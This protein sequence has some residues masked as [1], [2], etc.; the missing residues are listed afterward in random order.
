[1]GTMSNLLTFQGRLPG[2]VCEAALPPS[3]ETPLRLDVAAFV[4]FAERGP[5][6]LPVALEDLGQYQAVFGQDLLL[7]RTRLGGQVVYAAL[8][9]AVKAFFDNGGRRCYVVRVAG[10]NARP[11]HFRMPGL[12]AWDQKEQTFTTVIAPSAWVGRWSDGMRIGTQLRSVPLHLGQNPLA[13][14]A[15]GTTDGTEVL[16]LRLELPTA[17]TV[18]VHD[19]LRLQFDGPDQPFLFCSVESVTKTGI[20]VTTSRGIPVTIKARTRP[21]FTFTRER[22]V[23]LPAPAFVEKLTSSGWSSLTSSPLASTPT[24]AALAGGEYALSLPGTD[25]MGIAVGDL[26]RIT[27]ANNDVLLFPVVEVVKPQQGQSIASP[28]LASPLLDTSP[29]TEASVQIIS[30][31]ASWQFPYAASPPAPGM[32]LSAGVMSP[33]ADIYGNLSEVGLLNFDLFI[34]EGQE[35]QEI[36]QG[37]QFNGEMSFDTAA[38]NYWVNKLV[39]STGV[40]QANALLLNSAQRKLPGLDPTRSSRLG[41]PLPSPGDNDGSTQPWLFYL[42]LAMGELPS[43]DEFAPALP[44]DSPDNYP[45]P[46]K[47]GLWSFAPKDLFLDPHLLNVGVLDLI[48][49]ANQ[50]LYLNPG[51]YSSDGQATYLHKLHSLLLIDEIGLLSIPDLVQR[52]WHF[53]R[54]DAIKLPP[55][56]SPPAPP[57]WSHFQDCDQPPQGEPGETKPPAQPDINFLPVMGDPEAYDA[58]DLLFV[59]RAMVNF[60]AARS[61]VVAILSLPLHF[62]R[63]EALDWQRRFVAGPGDFLDSTL[64]PSLI[65]AYIDDTMLSYAAVYHPWLQIREQVT[66]QRS[67]LRAMPSDGAICGMIAARERARGPWIAPASVPLQ[68]IVGL[69]PNFSQTD[70]ADLFNAH[71]NIV[72]QPIAD[73]TL[74]SAH[75]LSSDTLFLHISVRRLLIFLRKLALRRGM[76]YAPR[77]A[78]G[79]C[80]RARAVLQAVRDRP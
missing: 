72:R 42:P 32:S 58:T 4:G 76:R 35:I 11:N 77:A 8:P 54:L 73:Y 31:G 55:P 60:C 65:P 70:W 48:N 16:A 56:S 25:T 63:R 28:P 21:E 39:P 5:L 22:R 45:V 7:A 2:T 52:P 59:Q 75:T 27:V 51:E 37:L 26:L 6:D 30:T 36:W 20:A 10:S 78:V 17:T 67:P 19:L 79:C 24:L 38:D 46:D 74:L 68:G 43:P 23:A 57:D 62:K 3:S 18:G 49:E 1:M 40:L 64:P 61:D 13:W 14:M 71:M 69:S 66:P 47:D 53:E 44:D 50:I 9:T 15:N 34:S 12:V 41:T 33:P 80:D 29:P